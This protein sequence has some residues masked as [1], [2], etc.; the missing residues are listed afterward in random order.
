MGK[1][2]LYNPYQTEMIRAYRLRFCLLCKKIGSMDDA[3]RFVC[4]TCHTEHASNLTAPHVFNRF[5]AFAGRRG[6]KTKVGAMVARSE[7]QI[8]KT[9]GWVMGPTFPVLRDSTMPTFLRLIPPHW[10]KNWSQD[11]LELTL[12]NDAQIMF[13][14]VDDPERARGQGP[15][16]GWL[17]E[18]AQA[19][20]RAWDVFRP[21]LSENAGIMLFTTTVLG[22]DW[23]YKRVEIPALKDHKPGFWA[24]RW[25][26]IDNPIFQH[27][28]VL[29]AEV[30]E[31]RSTMPPDMYAQEYLGER[32][33]FT[34][35]IYGEL[36]DRHV[37]HDDEAIRKF[38]PEW[39]KVDP[40]RTVL[41]G[42]DSGADH[43]FGAVMAVVTP[44]GIVVVDEYLQRMQAYVEHLMA[45]Q[46]AFGRAQTSLATWAANK[47]EAQLRIEFGLRNIG[48]VPVENDHKSGIQRVQSWLY[49]NQL[50]FA[51]TAPKT[52]EQCRMYRYAQNEKPDGQKKTKEEVFKKDDELPDGLRYLIMSW[53]ELPKSDGSKDVAET[54]RLA[55][56]TEKARYDLER[57]REYRRTREKGTELGIGDP[58]YPTGDFW[59]H[60]GV[61]E[62]AFGF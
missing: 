36:I 55:G 44:D 6:G 18:A 24:A 15:N 22:Y 48:V 47:N 3:S 34:G 62:D 7:A 39:P 42:L 29:R 9:L 37:L 23:T 43:P 10:V 4:P 8:P 46:Y 53:P 50:Y 2:I 20:E 38:I 21:S 16:W 52:I 25:R 41:I 27:N 40:S 49:S 45:I 58:G 33:N 61:T 60:D 1:P 26:T 57:A 56:F 17:D 19:S 54:Q 51:Y 12:T 31:A 32:R 35:A 28:P 5:G 11:A 14:S 13:R 30:E 59:G